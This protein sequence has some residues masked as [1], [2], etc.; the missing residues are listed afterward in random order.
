MPSRKQPTWLRILEELRRHGGQSATQLGKS[1]GMSAMGARQHLLR[2]ESDGLVLSRFEKRPTGRPTLLFELSEEASRHFPQSYDRFAE[3]LLRDIEEAGGREKV[4]ELF[5]RRRERLEEVYR[6]KL[7]NATDPRERAKIIAELRDTEGYM[8]EADVLEDGTTRLVE[9]NCP[10]ATVAKAYPEVCQ[11]ELELF[12]NLCEGD[13]R[14]TEHIVQGHH[15]CV[16]Y[17]SG[18]GATPAKSKKSK[19]S[20]GA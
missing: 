7:A 15:S 4:V 19:P 8:A 2:L 13:V 17:L 6:E 18:T 5:S 16:Y 11:A 12:Q 20:R 14:R 1:L 9:H 10:I 3:S